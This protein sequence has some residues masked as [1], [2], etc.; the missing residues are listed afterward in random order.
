MPDHEIEINKYQFT[1]WQ[2]SNHSIVKEINCDRK[3][4]IVLLS[5][6]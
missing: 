5:G 4:K 6:R 1:Q 3:H 2:E